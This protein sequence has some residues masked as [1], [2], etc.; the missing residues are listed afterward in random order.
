MEVKILQAPL[1]AGP[2]PEANATR[3]ELSLLETHPQPQSGF[4]GLEPTLDSLVATYGLT[5][6]YGSFEAVSQVTLEIRRGEIYGLLGPNGSGKTTTIRILL[7][8]LKQTEGTASLFGL[9]SWSR[10][11]EIRERVSFLPGEIRLFGHY[12]G[13]Q[14]LK[15][16]SSLRGGEPYQRAVAIAQEVMKLDL[17]K[18]VRNYSTGMKQK[19]ALSQAFADRVEVLILDEPTSALDPT[20][21]AIVLDLIR[22]AKARG[23]TVIF[24]GHVLSEV[25]QVCDRVAIMKQGRLMVVE[26]M[27]GRRQRLRLLLVKFGSGLPQSLPDSLELSVRRQ[28]SHDVLLLEHRGEAGP[29]LEWLNQQNVVDLAIGTDSLQDLYNQYHGMHSE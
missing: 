28:E 1:T 24:S 7:G 14:I 26:D 27:H 9:D 8:M 22:Q 19:L 4:A 18:K 20:A 23:Q 15:F 17:K 29:L 13:Y 3:R 12:T 2:C 5:K 11:R 10:S 16:L 25:E 6:R 21:R